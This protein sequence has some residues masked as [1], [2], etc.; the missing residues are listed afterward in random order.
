MKERQHIVAA[1]ELVQQHHHQHQQQVH[2][3]IILS[4]PHHP[5]SCNFCTKK[6]NPIID[7]STTH[8]RKWL[9]SENGKRDYTVK[10]EDCMFPSDVVWS[11]QKYVQ[12]TQGYCMKELRNF[13]M[14]L[15]SLELGLRYTGLANIQF[16]HFENDASTWVIKSGRIESLTQS[17][18]EK[19]EKQR[20]TYQLFFKDDT[21]KLCLLP[22]TSLGVGPLSERDAFQVFV[23]YIECLQ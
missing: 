5:T 6:G 17:V 19:A 18:R 21:P 3:T 4:C 14:L 11:I 15:N 9:I 8:L 20:S 1:A 16:Q 22:K 2:H 10:Q 23:Q 12:V 13:T 7:V